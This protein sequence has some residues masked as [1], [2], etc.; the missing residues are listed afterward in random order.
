[1][2]YDVRRCADDVWV[3]GA[4]G[5]R[6]LLLFRSDLCQKSGRT[7]KPEPGFVVPLPHSSG[8]SFRG[9]QNKRCFF[10]MPASSLSTLWSCTVHNNCRARVAQSSIAVL[11]V[12]TTWTMWL[13]SKDIM[14][15]KIV[16]KVLQRHFVDV[17]QCWQRTWSQKAG[18]L[19]RCS[20]WNPFR[21]LLDEK[22][23]GQWKITRWMTVNNSEHQGFKVQPEIVRRVVAMGV[24]M[25]LICTCLCRAT[26]LFS[27]CP[28]SAW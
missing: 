5:F 19:E 20:R 11:T 10:C 3:H 12:D 15:A 21:A 25:L 22:D 18:M 23:V 16:D 28:E 2:F 8:G 17:V 27:L 24:N 26:R 13:Q 7:R 4:A 14:S 1:M 6:Y 9:I